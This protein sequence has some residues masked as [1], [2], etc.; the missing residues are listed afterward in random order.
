MF[1][2][3]KPQSSHAANVSPQLTAN[4]SKWAISC[5]LSL[6]HKKPIHN[7]MNKHCEAIVQFILMIKQSDCGYDVVEKNVLEYGEL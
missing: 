3:A 2:A 1:K 5:L 7:N 6:A 4:S